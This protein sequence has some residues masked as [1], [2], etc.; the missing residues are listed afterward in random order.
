MVSF[1]SKD[2]RIQKTVNIKYQDFLAYLNSQYLIAEMPE[3][4]IGRGGLGL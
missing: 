1:N 4:S 3:Q 2:Y